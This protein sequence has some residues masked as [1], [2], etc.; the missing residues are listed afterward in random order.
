MAN[1]RQIHVSIWKDEWFLD[2]EPDQKLLFIYLFSNDLTSLSGIYKIAKKVIA[3]ETGLELK[4]V[5]DT[6]SKFEKD[7]RVYYRDGMVWVKHLRKYHSYTSS[8]VLTRVDNDLAEI[9]DCSLKQEYI[10]YYQQDI[11]YRYDIDTESY[12]IKE[13]ENKKKIEKEDEKESDIFVVYRSEIGALTPSIA[14]KINCAL[15]DYS[16]EWICEAIKIAAAN[17]KRSWGYAEAILKRWQV[18][19]FKTSN[20]KQKEQTPE[21]WL[22]A[23][24]YTI[25]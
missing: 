14:D 23:N 5:I 10:S 11:S 17:N 12:K 4:Y 25:H 13:K 20:H 16:E 7:G 15:E 6:L 8:K 1:Y 21:E 22:K 2:L 19:G 9:P 18:E 3:F 24:E